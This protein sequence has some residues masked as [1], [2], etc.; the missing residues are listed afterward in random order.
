M[1]TEQK[2]ATEAGGQPKSTRKA[3]GR[4][5][6][7]P[8]FGAQSP[9]EVTSSAPTEEESLVEGEGL[10]A[11]EVAAASA[12]AAGEE[13]AKALETSQRE[14][15]ENQDRL[16]RAQAE[17]ENLRKRAERDVENAHKFGIERFVSELL[18]VRDSMELGLIAS[19]EDG[20]DVAKVREG[21]ELTF[22]MLSTAMEKFGVEEVNPAG[23]RFDPEFHQAMSV[24][25]VEDCESGTV[26]TVV[27]KGYRLNGRLVRP[28]LVMV[29]K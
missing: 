18:P 13:L 23:A 26:T 20:A 19:R 6:G 28:A 8:P 9:P 21:F 1:G 16:L 10:S 12:P 14:L 15:D 7:P 4:G 22:R 29:A 5:A 2:T 25:E 24:Q 27:Q 11:A 17:L 3:K